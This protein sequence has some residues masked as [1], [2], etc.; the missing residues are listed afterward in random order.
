M[1]KIYY[2]FSPLKKG[3]FFMS[4]IQTIEDFLIEQESPLF[5]EYAMDGFWVLRNHQ[6]I[7]TGWS[8]ATLKKMCDSMFC[9]FSRIE[10][11]ASISTEEKVKIRCIA[12]LGHILKICPFSS[13]T[14]H[15][16]RAL[17]E[18]LFPIAV[19]SN[20]Q[21]LWQLIAK[22]TNFALCY[23]QWIIKKS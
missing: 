19:T 7:S 5:Y 4:H 9:L 17:Q 6:P 16:L 13:S 11:G 20:S 15:E 3:E 22:R 8:I 10:H 1:C 2:L 12:A 14:P 21:E 23:E 18:W